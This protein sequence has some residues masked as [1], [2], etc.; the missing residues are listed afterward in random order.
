MIRFNDL[1]FDVEMLTA[2]RDDG[3]VMRFTRQE[4]V[5]LLQL[6][7]R[8]GKLMT[9][10]RLA[11]LL[12]RD[13]DG[14]GDRNVDFLINRLRKRLGDKAHEPRFIATQYGEGYVWIAKSHE[15]PQSDTFLL[16]GPI[17]GLPATPGREQETLKTIAARFGDLLGQHR[18][19]TYAPQWTADRTAPAN[20]AYTFDGSL[21][22]DGAVLHAAFAL[23]RHPTRR[24]IHTIRAFFGAGDSK[25]EID[26]IASETRAAIWTHSANPPATLQVAPTDLPLEVSVHEAALALAQRPDRWCE[27]EAQLIHARAEHPD[28]PVLAVLWGIHL[29]LGLVRAPAE[30][31]T[32]TPQQ[33]AETEDTIEAIAL[34][35]LAAVRHN[36]LLVL[37]IAK[38]L[39]FV[40]RGHME[41]ARELADRTFAESTAFA[42]A[43]TIQA[44][45]RGYC[46]EFA[47]A[48][49]LFDLVMELSEP[50]S[51]FQMY[52]LILKCIGLMACGDRAGL[53]RTTD[54][55]YSIRQ[56][57]RLKIG[58][59][60]ADPSH[61]HL[62][63]DLEALLDSISEAAARNTLNYLFYM[64][65]R[66]FKA[67][68]HRHNVMAGLTTHLVRRFGADIVPARI[69][70]SIGRP[71]LATVQYPR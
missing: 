61:E 29:Y 17:Y 16:I 50:G 4:R 28:D 12:T 5:L 63:P 8:P 36:P 26:R 2:T 67:R 45:I 6:A 23:R 11:E 69:A 56:H 31:P 38:L 46:G 1:V 60:F 21:Y 39:L 54:R 30:G 13:G 64:S 66:R 22:E 44:Q 10:V 48:F 42:A 7:G 59:L 52:L 15:P 57:E 37:A 41:L 34:D 53:K 18:R 24:I 49:R 47:E 65:A 14:A 25:A 43:F 71:P 68:R 3:T 51:E 35:N 32:L 62:P 27:S 19:V 70:E 9:R 33:W 58:L 55:L 20:V 40:D